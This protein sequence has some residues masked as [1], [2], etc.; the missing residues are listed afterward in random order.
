LFNRF[1]KKDPTSLNFAGELSWK[2]GKKSVHTTTEWRRV[3]LNSKRK[4]KDGE[5]I[6][7]QDENRQVATEKE[8]RTTD[9]NTENQGGKEEE[10]T[11][12]RRREV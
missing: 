12:R 4:E 3:V 2:A 11:G 1:G 9:S 10:S 7:L 8:S 6:P 5:V